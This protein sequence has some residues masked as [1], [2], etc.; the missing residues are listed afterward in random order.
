V[1]RNVMRDIAFDR[2]YL[3]SAILMAEHK[4]FWHA[5]E[6]RN[7][8]QSTL[9]RRIQLLERRFATPLFERNPAGARQ[10]LAGERFRGE[11]AVWRDASSTGDQC[12]ACLKGTNGRASGP[13]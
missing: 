7:F 3:T 13:S 11:A 12:A 1:D 9:G 5:A 4:S 6:V 10:A 8:S 2:R